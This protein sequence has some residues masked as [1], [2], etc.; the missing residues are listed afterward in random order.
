MMFL[1]LNGNLKLLVL[2]YWLCPYSFILWDNFTSFHANFWNSILLF[3]SPMYATR[4]LCFH[5]NIRQMCIFLLTAGD[6][7]EYKS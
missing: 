2:V 4:Y 1:V 6:T 7:M 5:E 3:P